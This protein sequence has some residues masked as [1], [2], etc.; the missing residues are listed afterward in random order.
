MRDSVAFRLLLVACLSVARAQSQDNPITNGGFEQ[1]DAS[2]RPVDWAPMAPFA[3][4]TADVRS[5]NRA[6]RLT[7]K[8]PGEP[9]PGLNR[10]WAEGAGQRGSMI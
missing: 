4:E 7:L 8:L 6:L 10:A 9:D 2:G 5:G 1:L 3:I